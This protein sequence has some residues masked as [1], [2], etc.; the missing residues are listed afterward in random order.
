MATAQRSRITTANT[1]HLCGRNLPV[2]GRVLRSLASRFPPKVATGDVGVEQNPVISTKTWRDVT[3]G[4]G[5][6]TEEPKEDPVTKERGEESHD[7]AGS[8]SSEPMDAQALTDAAEE[9]ATTES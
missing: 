2:Q 4:V 3:G 1:V 7:E 5:V 6:E 8:E 9:E